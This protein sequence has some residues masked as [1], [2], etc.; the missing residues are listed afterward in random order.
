MSQL[1]WL[2]ENNFQFPAV[3]EALTEPDGLLTA[4]EYLSP[5]LVIDAYSQGIFPWYSD[6]Q[7]VLWWSPDPRCILYPDKFHISRSFRRTLNSGAFD[8]RTDTAFKEVMLACA[9]PRS[10]K[11]GPDEAGTWIT[12]TMLAVYC[13]LHDTGYGHSIECWHDGQLV[14]GMYGLVLG[15]IFFGESMFST[16]RDASKAAM[17]YLCTTINPYLVDAQ[18]YSDHLHTLGAEEIDRREFINIIKARSTFSLN[19]R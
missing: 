6:G 19:I 11:T 1:I 3:S 14:G 7:P 17:H 15:D 4:S 13:Q 12:D 5:E 10:N 2:E 8:I 18:V 16:M 9:A